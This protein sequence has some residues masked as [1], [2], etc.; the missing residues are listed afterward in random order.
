MH[1]TVN[2]D[3]RDVPGPL[4]ITDLLREL[5]FGERRVAVEVNLEIV[6]RSRHGSHQLQ[7]G[8]RVELVQAIGGG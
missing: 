6:P 5:G 4:S 8:D 2:G 3:R 1:I 7:D